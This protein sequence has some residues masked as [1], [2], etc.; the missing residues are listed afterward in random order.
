M[1]NAFE[2]SVSST[3]LFILLLALAAVVVPPAV[4]GVKSWWSIRLRRWGGS[5]RVAQAWLAARVR[6][7]LRRFLDGPGS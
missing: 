1:R 6:D 3:A 2:V 7:A 5:L 4:S